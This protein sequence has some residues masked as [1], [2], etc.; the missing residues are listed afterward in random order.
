MLL[1]NDRQALLLVFF[2]RLRLI[3]KTIDI[4]IYQRIITCI[5]YLL[6]KSNLS[7]LQ[8]KKCYHC[9]RMANRDTFIIQLILWQIGDDG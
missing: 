2:N 4:C 1:E 8:V 7:I 5:D 9:T 6:S 3:F